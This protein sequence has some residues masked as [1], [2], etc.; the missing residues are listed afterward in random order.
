MTYTVFLELFM[1]VIVGGGMV[2]YALLVV[3]GPRFVGYAL[4]VL[5]LSFAALFTTVTAGTS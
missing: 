1:A 4:A 2:L 3:G 5:L